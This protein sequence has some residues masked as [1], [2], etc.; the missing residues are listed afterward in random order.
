MATVLDE[1]A[2][3]V[4]AVRERVGPSVVGVN[5]DGSG[6]VV[7]DG[8]VAT[9]AHNLRGGEPVVTFPDG[10]Q[11][12]GAVAGVDVDGDLAVVRVDTGGAPAVQWAD[13]DAEPGLAVFGVA[14]P[15][16]RG[17][18]VTFG[19]VSSVGRPFRGP[20]GRRV[21]ASVEHTAPLPPGSSGGPVVDAAGRVVGLNTH[22]LGEGFYLALP[23]TEELRTSLDG[24]AEGRSRTRLRLGVA[25]A[26]A[27]AARKLREAVGLPEVA[28][29]LVRAVEEDGPAARAGIRRGDVLTSARAGAGE[30][31]VLGTPDDLHEAL[32][33]ATDAL[34]LTVV[35]GVEE[36]T[37]RVTFDPPAA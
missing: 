16:G 25:L 32:D 22:R 17:L 6:V 4:K 11:A 21:P 1:V 36:I 24:L 13:A 9:N 5:R 33:A 3:T 29:L 34:E 31:H 35:R 15:G 8:L 28:G 27:R 19:T 20:R 18:R 2:T 7:G 26:P 30:A 10:R 12:Q 37:V 14:N 23:V